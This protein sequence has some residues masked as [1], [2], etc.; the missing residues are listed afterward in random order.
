MSDTLIVGLAAALLT[1][2][3]NL[4]VSIRNGKKQDVQAVKTEQIV[5]ATNGT[6]S[7]LT[8]TNEVL[9]ARIAGLERLVAEMDTSKREAKD[10]AEKQS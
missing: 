3:T 7:S 10:L 6:L 5:T 1:A 9:V 2:V 4:V 8:K